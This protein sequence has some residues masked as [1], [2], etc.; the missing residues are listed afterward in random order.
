VLRAP[1]TEIAR[2]AKR[3]EPRRMLMVNGANFMRDEEKIDR[4]L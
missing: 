3:D 1:R 4:S 2:F